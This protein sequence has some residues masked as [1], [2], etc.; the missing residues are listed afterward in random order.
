MMTSIGPPETFK[1][2]AQADGTPRMSAPT[3]ACT[4][5]PDATYGG[6]HRLGEVYSAAASSLR[7]LSHAAFVPKTR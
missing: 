3:V 5:V 6:W 1:A 4:G 7:S 2:A